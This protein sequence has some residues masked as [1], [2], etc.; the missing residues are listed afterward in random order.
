MTEVLLEGMGSEGFGRFC[1]AASACCTA[2]WRTSAHAYTHT[3]PAITTIKQ[4]EETSQP[5]RTNLV[6]IEQKLKIVSKNSVSHSS[7]A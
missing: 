5:I 3:R 6:I 1:I 2:S 7:N 4:R